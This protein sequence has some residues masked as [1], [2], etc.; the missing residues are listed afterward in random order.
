[1]LLTSFT[2]FSLWIKIF[3]VFP[4]TTKS[5]NL[6]S[7]EGI[8][9]KYTPQP[10]MAT[11]ICL[12]TIVI[13]VSPFGYLKVPGDQSHLWPPALLALL[14]WHQL[15]IRAERM[16]LPLQ[17]WSVLGS[18][19]ALASLTCQSSHRLNWPCRTISHTHKIMRLLKSWSHYSHKFL[20]SCNHKL[21]KNVGK[22]A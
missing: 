6:L 7:I 12:L 3:K 14:I 13:S 9:R 21:R 1:M 19:R 20:K 17:V 15:E 8:C 16:A 11:E 4:P 5:T 22:Q 10:M 2:K 18:T